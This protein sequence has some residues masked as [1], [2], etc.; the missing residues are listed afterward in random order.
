MKV[1]NLIFCE[2]SLAND[3][4]ITS[5]ATGGYSFFTKR[6]CYLLSLLFQKCLQFLLIDFSSLLGAVSNYFPNFSIGLKSG[7]CVGQLI[8]AT[9][10]FYKIVLTFLA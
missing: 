3:Y 10:Y 6:R 5:F 1:N 2:Y 9:I 8:S 4:F 7:L